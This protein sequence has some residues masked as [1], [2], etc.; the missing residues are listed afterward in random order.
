MFF[1]IRHH[2]D[3]SSEKK[4]ITVRGVDKHLYDQ[5]VSLAG[6]AGGS[7][8]TAFS[9]A[10]SAHKKE[11]QRYFI[12]HRIRKFLHTYHDESVEVIENHE[13]LIISK[14]DLISVGENIKFVFK[15][16]DHLIFDESVDNK[17]LLN[18]VYRIRNCNV[19]AKGEI[20]KLFLLS[21]DQ[22]NIHKLPLSNDFKDITIRNVNSS[23]YEEFVSN[24]QATKQNIGDCVNDML[25][26]I[27]PHYE[28]LQILAHETSLN[29]LH[30]IILSLHDDLS[31]E[32]NDLDEIKERKILF[33]RIKKLQFSENIASETFIQSVIGI[34]NCNE[35]HL[36]ASVPKLIKLSR[37]KDYPDRIN[38]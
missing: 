25:S 4:T 10:I 33:H 17:T 23:A 13:E 2:Q 35:V 37:V 19:E 28:V 30:P 34:Y 21:I 36:P 24:C 32:Q 20:S 6:L 9:H 5:F 26:Q 15:N 31:I 29:T 22:S 27:I 1:G 16:I 7:I 18:C 11:F 3:N 12:P 8:G 14:E 38:T